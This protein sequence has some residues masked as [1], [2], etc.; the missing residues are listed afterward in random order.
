M[1][2]NVK[3]F[4]HDE[5]L[6]QVRFPAPRSVA[7]CCASTC[8]IQELK[9]KYSDS[10]HKLHFVARLSSIEAPPF[11][12]PSTVTHTKPKH[13]A[14]CLFDVVRFICTGE[15]S[16]LVETCPLAGNC[17]AHVR[18]VLHSTAVCDLC[19]AAWSMSAFNDEDY[20]FAVATASTLE[21]PQEYFEAGEGAEVA[22][23]ED[24][25]EG[26]FGREIAMAIPEQGR[27]RS[28]SLSANDVRIVNIQPS[29]FVQQAFS[30]NRTS[31]TK[32]STSSPTSLQ[33]RHSL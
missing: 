31:P 27:T 26:V 14:M 25:T 32:A 19:A 12:P 7:I 10:L 13:Q 18:H 11:E 16:T 24:G 9:D 8:G 2:R 21:E 1:T 33:R 28:F 4:N 6:G 5:K 20:Q 23:V 15:Q 17:V 29:G 30:S 22:A 3:A